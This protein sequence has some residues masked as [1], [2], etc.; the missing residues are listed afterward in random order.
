MSAVKGSKQHP[1]RVVPHRPVRRFLMFVLTLLVIA[2]CVAGAYWGGYWQGM[3]TQAGA[4]KQVSILRDQL[5]ASEQES[6][7]LRQQV[8]NLSLASEVDQYASEEVRNEI[9]SL[10]QEVANLET[11]ISFYRGLMAPSEANSGLTIGEVNIVES[12]V[13]GRYTF[14]IVMQ[15]LATNHQVLNGELRVD[16]VGRR[17]GV[18]TRVPLYQLADSIEEED[19]KLRFKYF[20]NIEGELTLPEGFEVQKLELSAESSGRNSVKVHKS[21]GWLVEDR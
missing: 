3:G 19:I 10:R 14:K 1:L 8:A 17:D 11:D 20:Q 4:L 9:V 5:Q 15:Q 21:Y 2:A 16:V 7:D 13:P 6:A 12:A 18:I